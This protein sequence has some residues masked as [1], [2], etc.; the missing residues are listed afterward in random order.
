M[1]SPRTSGKLTRDI[2]RSEPY[3]VLGSE[4]QRLRVLMLPLALRRHA[5][6]EGCSCLVLGLYIR[7]IESSIAVI[8]GPVV[9]MMMVSFVYRVLGLISAR[10]DEG[11]RL[12]HLDLFLRLAV[13]PVP[14]GCDRHTKYSS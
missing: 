6:F 7:D 2:G 11:K 12:T 10:I 4:I 14:W 8:R 5:S 1:L 13:C 3:G 9:F